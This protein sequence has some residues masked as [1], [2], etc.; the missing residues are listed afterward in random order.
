MNAHGDLLSR[1]V[2]KS[3]VPPYVPTAHLNLAPLN[4]LD[5]FF[6]FKRAGD[7]ADGVIGVKAGAAVDL[8]DTATGSLTA[9]SHPDAIASSGVSRHRALR[10]RCSRCGRWIRAAHASC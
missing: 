8:G 1:P 9:A 2:A 6:D 7:E 10:G 4:P 5:E 3:H